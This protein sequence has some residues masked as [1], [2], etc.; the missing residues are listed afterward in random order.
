MF[1]PLIL[2]YSGIMMDRMLNGMYKV[3]K[4]EIITGTI[5]DRDIK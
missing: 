3:Y 2:S 4:N 5:N 1:L